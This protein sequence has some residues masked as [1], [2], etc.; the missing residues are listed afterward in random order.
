MQRTRQSGF[1]L[2]EIGVTIVIFCLLATLVVIG[3][4]FTANS[5][6]HRLEHDFRSLQTAIYD[7]Q[8]W[9]RSTLGDFR[10]ASFNL[11]DSVA[12]GN[13]SNLN[14]IL[15]ESWNSSSGATFNLWQS[16]RPTGLAQ[17]S[18]DVMP[19]AYAPLKLSGNFF[20]VSETYNSPIS[21]LKGNFIICTNNVAGRLAKKIDLVMDDGNTAS[22]SMRVSGSIGGTAI[23]VDGVVDS[24]TY[25]VCL[26]V[27]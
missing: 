11:Q 10:K 16:V 5:Q 25:L 7:S 21:G 26:D 22:G 2:F 6:V 18:S 12:F 1:T 13:G 23:A 19:N 27:R 20:G 4:N 3:Q 24:S 9:K 15:G 8:D 14:A 17:N